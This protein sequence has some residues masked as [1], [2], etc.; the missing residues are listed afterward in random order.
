MIKKENNPYTHFVIQ[1]QNLTEYL[2][3]GPQVHP[4]Y[5]LLKKYIDKDNGQINVIY[6]NKYPV[7][8]E[9][10]K[11]FG[12]VEIKEP[13]QM[14]FLKE[15][16]EYMHQVYKEKNIFEFLIENNEKEGY[17]QIGRALNL[18]TK[19]IQL[20]Y[21]N[22]QP[23]FIEEENEKDFG[24]IKNIKNIKNI[25][26]INKNLPLTHIVKIK[27]HDIKELKQIISVKGY[28]I[29]KITYEKGVIVELINTIPVYTAEESEFGIP[30]YIT[31]TGYYYGKTTSATIESG[32]NELEETYRRLLE[33]S[34]SEEER[35]KAKEYYDKN[36]RKLKKSYKEDI[37][38]WAMGTIVKKINP[39]YCKIYYKSKDKRKVTE[40]Y[41]P[42]TGKYEIDTKKI[43][44][45]KEIKKSDNMKYVMKKP[46]E[47]LII[48]EY[49]M[50]EYIKKMEEIPGYI[51][52]KTKIDM[53]TKKIKCIF[54]NV[55]KVYIEKEEEF[56]FPV[57]R[58]IKSNTYLFQK[59]T[60]QKNSYDEEI[61]EW[62]E[63]ISQ[64]QI[65]EY[66]V[67]IHYKNKE[68]ITVSIE[69][70]FNPE[71]GIYEAVSVIPEKELT[72]TRK[73]VQ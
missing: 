5:I 67:V 26:Y 62:A 32:Q 53:K 2:K 27:I 47:H 24:I 15:L 64:D 16:K 35:K 12:Y 13:T 33:K 20:L 54:T 57:M 69:E 25:K 63:V 43:I 73:K 59:I 23:V 3:K 37:P 30:E 14:K 49:T 9:E 10:E 72:R 18:S 68:G 39:Y 17:E 42:E 4:A 65:T 6:T 34:V 19:K 58:N 1:T 8:I 28:K 41:N 44:E 50:L 7:I 31:K 70:R 61:P 36:K 38:N 71:K 66:C 21:Q 29:A 45:R 46:Y 11:E 48:K 52:Q 60:S 40:K 51:C 22:I 56:G 55:L